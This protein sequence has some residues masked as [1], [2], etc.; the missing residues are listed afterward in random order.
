LAQA[1]ER[2]RDAL[3]PLIG[4]FIVAALV[5]CGGQSITE[6][7]FQRAAGDGASLTS[8][9]AETLRALHDDPPRLTV[10]YGQS[11]TFNYLEQLEPIRQSLPTL[12]GAPDAATLATLTATLDVA[13]A[14]L[15]APCLSGACDWQAQVT[16]LDAAKQA[17]LGASE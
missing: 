14:D 1:I 11:A 13:I 12:G 7:A 5:A 3:K 4:G 17:L 10:E 2:F 8:A 9:G 15:R 16:H 6:T